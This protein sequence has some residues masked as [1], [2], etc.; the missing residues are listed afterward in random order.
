MVSDG[1]MCVLMYEITLNCV[2]YGDLGGRWGLGL[3]G[4]IVGLP[5]RTPRAS[6]NKTNN[7][8]PCDQK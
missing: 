8:T 7:D 5:W 4:T 6:T 2:S 3:V 1:L